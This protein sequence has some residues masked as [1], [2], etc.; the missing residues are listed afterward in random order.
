MRTSFVTIATTM[1]LAA[2]GADAPGDDGH[3]LLAAPLPDMETQ[4][5]DLLGSV[6]D[7]IGQEAGYHINMLTQARTADGRAVT[8]EFDGSAA[9]RSGDHRGADPWFN[10]LIVIGSEG[11]RVRLTV[12]GGGY[13]VA[14]YK[15]ELL[16]ASNGPVDL[17]DGGDAVPLAG[18]WQRSGLHEASPDRFS[19]ACAGAVAYKCTRWGYLA[20]SDP[21]SLGWRAHQACTRMARGDYCANGRTHTREGTLINIS[22]F[23]GVTDRPPLKFGGVDSW[24]PPTDRFYFEAAWSDGAYPA[25]CLSRLRW[26][27]LPLGPLC[28][29]GGP[30]TVDH[31]PDPRIDTTARFCEDLE[32]PEPGSAPAGALLFNASRYN[33]LAIQLW[34]AGDDYVT[35]V[36]G[37]YDPPLT[38][39]PFLKAGE[40]S[41]VAPDAL[42]IRSL[43]RSADPALFE[44]AYVYTKDGDKVIAGVRNPP[45]GFTIG[46]PEGLVRIA[47]TQATVAFTM[48]RHA[49]TGDYLSMAGA[50]PAGYEPLWTIGYV[51]PPE[52]R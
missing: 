33:D 47:K 41:F 10:G 40:Y 51:T 32:W 6:L 34:R 3:G 13:D 46:Q 7:G 39:E 31:L 23:A 20:G 1:W 9:L 17:C 26:Q 28:G 30:G 2:C 18:K 22:D 43:P 48:Y 50:P 44:E 29:S 5:Q 35:T 21:S 4:G 11:A 16:N 52:R 19:F 45:P 14:F 25:K 24:P 38:R 36:R 12:S 37:L 49:T 15:L 8:V 42:L 27:S